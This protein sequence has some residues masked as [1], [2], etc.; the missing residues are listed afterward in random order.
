MRK[1]LVKWTFNLFGGAFLVLGIAGIF[2]PLLPAT[3]FLLLAGFCFSKGSGHFHHWLINHKILGPPIR[4]W[5]YHGVIRRSSKLLATTM[6]GISALWILP[7][8]TIPLMGKSAFS[9]FSSL[10]LIFIWTR[11]SQPPPTH[12]RRETQ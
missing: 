11:P 4:D 1:S 12:L 2:L 7:K 9:L 5:K 8:E 6:L 10:I 3:P